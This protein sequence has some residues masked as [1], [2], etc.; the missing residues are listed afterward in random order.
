MSGLLGVGFF[1]YSLGTAH[2]ARDRDAAVAAARDD[3]RKEF[4]GE[5]YRQEVIAQLLAIIRSPTVGGQLNEEAR[6]VVQNASDEIDQ[7][8][9]KSAAEL[10]PGVVAA[11]ARD[12]VSEDQSVAVVPGTPVETCHVY[13]TKALIGP[14]LNADSEVRVTIEGVAKNIM[15]GTAYQVGAADC[16]LLVERREKLEDRDAIWVSFAC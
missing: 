10:L 9:L 13:G 5:E 8:D 11:V 16:D 4:E 1:G 6:Q 3:L 7:G 2:G 15:F 12:C 14:V